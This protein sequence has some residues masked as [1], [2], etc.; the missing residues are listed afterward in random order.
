MPGSGVG[1]G[2]F[3]FDEHGRAAVR[4]LDFRMQVECT[5]HRFQSCWSQID[6]WLE[7][8]FNF[9]W[10]GTCTLL[11]SAVFWDFPLSSRLVFVSQG[12]SFRDSQRMVCIFCFFCISSLFFWND[13]FSACFPMSLCWFWH[14]EQGAAAK[15][16]QLGTHGSGHLGQASVSETS[17]VFSNILSFCETSIDFPKKTKPQK[18]S[19]VTDLSHLSVLNIGW[20]W[21]T[22]W[23]LLVQLPCW[24]SRST[25]QAWWCCEFWRELWSRTCTRNQA[26][27]GIQH[28]TTAGTAR[29]D[30]KHVQWFEW[31]W[32]ISVWNHWLCAFREE[33]GLEICSPQLLDAPAL[34]LDSLLLQLQRAAPIFVTNRGCYCFIASVFFPILPIFQPQSLMVQTHIRYYQIYHFMTCECSLIQGHI[35]TIGWE[36]LGVDR[37]GHQ[38]FDRFEACQIYDDT[39]QHR[40]SMWFYIRLRH[41]YIIH[42][43]IYGLYIHIMNFDI[44][45]QVLLA[46]M[47]LFFDSGY[48]KTIHPSYMFGTWQSIDSLPWFPD[49]SLNGRLLSCRLHCRIGR[50]SCGWCQE[51]GASTA[52][53]NESQSQEVP[54]KITK[55]TMQRSSRQFKS[56]RNMMKSASLI[57]RCRL[58]LFWKRVRSIDHEVFFFDELTVETKQEPEAPTGSQVVCVCVCVF[59]SHAFV[60][61]S[62]QCLRAPK[63]LP[64]PLADFTANAL[65]ALRALR[66]HKKQPD[67]GWKIAVRR[68]LVCFF[69]QKVK[70]VIEHSIT[71]YKANMKLIVICRYDMQKLNLALFAQAEAETSLGQQVLD[72]CWNWMGAN[73]REP[74]WFMEFAKVL[75]P[76]VEHNP[77]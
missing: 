45:K 49:S 71:L 24:R 17:F 16:Q 43:N 1:V 77:S 66:A 53:R 67:G 27:L 65:P 44:F 11:S 75:L 30:L 31:M 58:E 35:G 46:V 70:G 29:K 62:G 69:L 60:C 3:I 33:T 26:G 32:H 9:Q 34:H 25:A 14:F 56:R 68:R 55:M 72:R 13:S 18:M 54:T 7:T 52:P 19:H 5:K 37:P 28:W 63:A 10:C 21:W 15:A 51:H 42:D 8:R 57:W 36:P 40:Y 4:N 12:S 20:C 2:A 41:S 64:T 74:G 50:L 73:G 76:T 59:F 48:T 39:W 23:T 22:S 6:L 47:I 38:L 61:L